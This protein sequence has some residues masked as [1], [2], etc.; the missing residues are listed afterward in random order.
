MSKIGRANTLKFD[1]CTEGK[2]GIVV[3]AASATGTHTALLGTATTNHGAFIGSRNCKAYHTEVAGNQTHQ[4]HTK[5]VKDL[6]SCNLCMRLTTAPIQVKNMF[7]SSRI[8]EQL[9]LARS[10]KF[11]SRPSGTSS[12]G[13]SIEAAQADMTLPCLQIPSNHF[14]YHAATDACKQ[15][16]ERQLTVRDIYKDTCKHLPNVQPQ[17]S[18][19]VRSKSW[20]HSP[21]N[22]ASNEDATCLLPP[23]EASALEPPQVTTA[24]YKNIA[25]LAGA[26]SWHDTTPYISTLR[27]IVTGWLYWWLPTSFT[28]F[29]RYQWNS[30]SPRI[31]QQSNQLRHLQHY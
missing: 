31:R 10:K 13:S 22:V 29:V 20:S 8:L 30:S 18:E 1:P 9:L 14:Q 19:F 21:M 28:T 2:S 25:S 5:F 11:D 6:K 17:G 23:D 26:P 16:G 15:G 12:V 7:P 3:I 24:R 4:T 27:V